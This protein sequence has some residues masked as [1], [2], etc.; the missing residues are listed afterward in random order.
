MMRSN[1]PLPQ[2]VT[3]F[4]EGFELFVR[5]AEPRCQELELAAGDA[6]GAFKKGGFPQALQHGWH[7][8][9]DALERARYG[10][11]S[12]WRSNLARGVFVP[13]IRDPDNNVI[14]ELDKK[15]WAGSQGLGPYCFIDDFVCPDDPIVPGPLAANRREITTSVFREK[16]I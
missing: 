5:S 9:L 3:R 15:G 16:H 4:S 11:W 10:A 7:A 13:C 12:P 1:D 8:A 2:N 14:L 6:F